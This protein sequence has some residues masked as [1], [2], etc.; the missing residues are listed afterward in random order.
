M[1]NSEAQL[2]QF[3]SRD[4]GGGKARHKHYSMRYLKGGVVKG[5]TGNLFYIHAEELPLCLTLSGRHN[6]WNPKQ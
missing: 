5:P 3:G 2:I 1:G 6:G 4:A